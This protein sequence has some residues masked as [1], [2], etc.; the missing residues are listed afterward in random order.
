FAGERGWTAADLDDYVEM[1]LERLANLKVDFEIGDAIDKLEKL[2]I[3]EKVGD[4]YRAHPL[5][6]ALEMLDYTW[7]NY[8]KYANPE[9]ETP[10]RHK[11]VE[12]VASPWNN[13]FKSATP[14]PEP[15]P[16]P[17]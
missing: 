3:V 10:P 2:R 12:L 13:Y 5:H 11:P 14:E 8:F 16:I 1:D 4:R 9:P 15:P 6:K 7:D 17:R